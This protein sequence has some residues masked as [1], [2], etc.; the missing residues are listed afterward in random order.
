MLAPP[1]GAEEQHGDLVGGE[2]FVLEDGAEH[3]VVAL[4]EH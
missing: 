2:D 3:R 4:V 1:E